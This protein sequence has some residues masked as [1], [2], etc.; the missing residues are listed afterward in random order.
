MIPL[1]LIIFFKSVRPMAFIHHS[2]LN[3]RFTPRC[4]DLTDLLVII[5]DALNNFDV[6]CVHCVDDVL[7]EIV[8]MNIIPRK[9]PH[10]FVKD[11]EKIECKILDEKHTI[12]RHQVK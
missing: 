12:N 10:P 7:D 4:N 9:L 6:I 3:C 8:N 1:L 5:L 11:L 2:E